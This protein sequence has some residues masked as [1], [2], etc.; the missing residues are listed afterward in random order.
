MPSFWIISFFMLYF[1]HLFV[2]VCGGMG[3]SGWA[4]LLSS[5][6]CLK[7]IPVFLFDK[8]MNSQE[9]QTLNQR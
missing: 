4:G 1:I 2:C 5:D 9:A 7:L 8:N 6:T 3:W